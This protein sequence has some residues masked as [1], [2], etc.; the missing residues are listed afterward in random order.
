MRKPF[1]VKSPNLWVL[2]LKMEHNHFSVK[3]VL[4][5]L[6]KIAVTPHLGT[7]DPFTLPAFV[8]HLVINS[9]NR[10]IYSFYP[11]NAIV[12]I[13]PKLSKNLIK[14]NLNMKQPK[15]LFLVRGQIFFTQQFS[16]YCSSISP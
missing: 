7:P 10:I 11:E 16:E 4:A 9:F 2:D 3:P 15:V 12:Q 13:K 1:S 8:F 6:T 5:T 14:Y